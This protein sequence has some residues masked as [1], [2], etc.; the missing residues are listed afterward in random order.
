V[1]CSRDAAFLIFVLVMRR[2]CTFAKRC[3]KLA[4]VGSS[5]HAWLCTAAYVY[6][7]V[8]RSNELCKMCCPTLWWRLQ[9]IRPCALSPT[10]VMFLGYDLYSQGVSLC[11]GRGC[12]WARVVLVKPRS[13]CSCVW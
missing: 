11:V 5:F 9:F 1:S 13:V 3:V 4:V 6:H 10:I 2:A 7:D 12:V 8:L